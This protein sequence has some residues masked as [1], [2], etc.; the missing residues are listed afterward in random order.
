LEGA[1]A[2]DLSVVDAYYETL[3][4]MAYEIEK[5]A[6]AIARSA[7]EKF[8]RHLAENSIACLKQPKPRRRSSR[9]QDVWQTGGARKTVWSADGDWGS[10][11]A[12]SEVEVKPAML[13]DKGPNSKLRFSYVPS[14]WCTP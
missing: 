6:A 13:V 12:W 11:M 7:A 9:S 10:E 4:R 2:D 8:D 3:S 5:K 14:E 1:T